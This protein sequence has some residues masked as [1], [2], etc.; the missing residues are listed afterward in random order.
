MEY[1]LYIGTR[2][3]SIPYNIYVKGYTYKAVQDPNETQFGQK[4]QVT[5]KR[6]HQGVTQKGCPNYIKIQINT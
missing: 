6:A 5:K 3:T 4:H 2:K 1:T